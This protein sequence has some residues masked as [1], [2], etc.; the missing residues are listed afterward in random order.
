M[1]LKFEK[2]CLM[3]KGDIVVQYNC[4][5]EAA[6]KALYNNLSSQIRISVLDDDHRFK[7]IPIC[8]IQYIENIDSHCFLYTATDSYR[9]H[10]TFKQL[11]K[12]LKDVNFIQINNITLVNEENIESVE[13]LPECKRLV[14]IKSGERLLVSRSFKDSVKHLIGK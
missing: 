8:D 1:N 14:T 12:K 4:A 6:Q 11:H 9:S 7:K 10:L 5:K 3:G 13:I 2:N